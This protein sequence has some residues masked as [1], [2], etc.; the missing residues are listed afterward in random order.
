MIRKVTIRSASI[1]GRIGGWRVWLPN[2]IN[3]KGISWPL[4]IAIDHWPLIIDH[5]SAH[6]V[7]LTCPNDTAPSRRNQM[8]R[9]QLA[10]RI[11]EASKFHINCIGSIS[12]LRIIA[13][14]HL[15]ST[16][17]HLFIWSLRDGTLSFEYFEIL[18]G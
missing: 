6:K 4:I 10:W 14:S 1:S 17:Q 11:L 8:K 18:S 16:S 12:D 2:G 5:W 3:F 13:P 9:C 7:I 15:F